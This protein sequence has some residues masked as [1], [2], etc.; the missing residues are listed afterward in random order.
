MATCVAAPSRSNK[1]CRVGQ[2]WFALLQRRSQSFQFKDL[3][4]YDFHLLG[5]SC[6][7]SGKLGLYSQGL[8][9]VSVTA[10]ASSSI[11]RG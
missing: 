4:C 2:F 11:G 1:I 3:Y 8:W 6:E 9:D 7:I 5:I 10:W